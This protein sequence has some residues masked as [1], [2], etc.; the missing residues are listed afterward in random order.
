MKDGHCLDQGARTREREKWVDSACFKVES[1]EV[2][3]ELDVAGESEQKKV[4][5]DGF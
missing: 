3:D 1:T 4:F 2:T 5:S